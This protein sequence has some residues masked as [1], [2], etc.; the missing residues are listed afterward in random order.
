MNKSEK[1]AHDNCIC[2]PPADSKYCSPYCESARD[3]EEISCGCGHSQCAVV[4]KT[5]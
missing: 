5:A 2:T 3:T 1:C 4:A